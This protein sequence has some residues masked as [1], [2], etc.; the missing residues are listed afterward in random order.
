MRFPV[1]CAT[2]AFIGFLAIPGHVAGQ[3]TSAAGEFN[4][5]DFDAYVL[6]V[7]QDQKVP[8]VEIAIIA[9]IKDRSFP[10]HLPKPVPARFL[11]APSRNWKNRHQSVVASSSSTRKSADCQRIINVGLTT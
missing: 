2:L 6:R 10:S 8:G 9:I 5:A 3:P 1:V 4:R 7:M 11:S